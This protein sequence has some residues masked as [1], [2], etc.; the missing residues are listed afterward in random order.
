[1]AEQD[2]LERKIGWRV[3]D[4]INKL[5]TEKDCPVCQADVTMIKI[6]FEPHDERDWETIWKCLIC[7]TLWKEELV[8]G[9]IPPPKPKENK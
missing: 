2:Y 9:E 3:R 8:K 6:E 5:I 1:M 4:E 7:G